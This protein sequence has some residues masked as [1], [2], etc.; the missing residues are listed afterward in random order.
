MQRNL[1][2]FH[3]IWIIEINSVT[4]IQNYKSNEENQ[5]FIIASRPNMENVPYYMNVDLYFNRIN[6]EMLPFYSLICRYWTSLTFCI[7]YTVPSRQSPFAYTSVC[8]STNAL[9]R[10]RKRCVH[11]VSLWTVTY[12]LFSDRLCVYFQFSKS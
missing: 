11:Y 8:Y 4:N 5:T 1:C 6:P 7:L 2:C 3:V 9:R 10:F 12:E